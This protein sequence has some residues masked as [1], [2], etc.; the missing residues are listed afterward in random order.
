MATTDR[1]HFR[2]FGEYI[3]LPGLLSTRTPEYHIASSLRLD[4]NVKKYGEN[5]SSAYE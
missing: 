3:C 4:V 2:L 1:A 5:L